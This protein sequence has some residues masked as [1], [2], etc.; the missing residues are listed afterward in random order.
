MDVSFGVSTWVWLSPFKTESVALLPKIK[1]MGFDVV[2]IPVEDPTIIDGKRVK[3]ALE[4]YDLKPV[5]C[6]AFGPSRDLTSKDPTDH[7]TCFDY[8][9]ALMD[10]CEIWETD[11]VAGPMYSAVGKTRMLSPED[12]KA[13]WELAVQNLRKVAQKAGE[14]GLELAIEP[15]NRFESDLVNTT[16]DVLRMT[17]D[18][19]HPAAKIM[20]DGFHMSIEERSLEEAIKIA[21]DKLIHV[22]VS[23]NYRGTPGTGQTDWESFRRGLEAINYQ[24]Y[25]NIESF[26]S[27]N[28]ELA[29][30]VCIWKPFADDQDQ[31]AREGLTFLEKT[32]K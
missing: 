11:F 28:Q 6:G 20:V 9:G 14:R 2:E 8:L 30:A 3:E 12:R 15:L 7:Q 27:D 4:K 16:E 24:G 32:F 19:G 17:E 29:D 5:V 21:G 10:L 31:L 1:E 13:E 25:V 23:E 22:Q 18:I 26:T